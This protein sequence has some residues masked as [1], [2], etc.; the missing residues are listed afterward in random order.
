MG[1]KMS[2]PW[3]TASVV[4]WTVAGL[5]DWRGYVCADAPGLAVTKDP[6]SN[7]WRVTH[8]ASGRGIA[9]GSL[10]AEN[11]MGLALELARLGDFTRPVDDVWSDMGLCLAARSLL[12]RALDSGEYEDIDPPD[13]PDD[14]APEHIRAMSEAA[15]AGAA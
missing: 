15:E 11:V 14:R 4:I 7:L 8:T 9:I 1:W 12:R 10:D 3:T 2:A 5:R 13:S 6:M